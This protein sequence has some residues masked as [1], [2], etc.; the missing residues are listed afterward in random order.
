MHLGIGDPLRMAVVS[1][2]APT[3]QSAVVGASV[4]SR[5][6]PTLRAD[7]AAPIT[8]TVKALNAF[9]PRLLVG[10]ASAL[11]ELAAEQAAGRLRIQ[12][13]AVI[14]ASEVLTATTA[15]DL[16]AAWGHEPF[17]V[18]AATETAGIASP[19]Q[20]HRRHLYEDLVICEVV[21]DTGA[22]VPAG[23]TGSRLL[24]TVLFSRTLPLIR[25]ELSD[26]VAL[27]PSSCPCARP[28]RTLAGVEGR[29]EDIL[30]LPG[31]RGAV[32]GPPQR[33]ARSPSTPCRSPAGRSSRNR[34]AYYAC[35]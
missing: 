35:W 22:P 11:R 6:V 2:L 18:Y 23:T 1:S 25:Y 27:D 17:D 31:A 16:A 30:M 9:A 28:F 21:D 32:R 33:P 20:F 26:R 29:Q 5:L 4:H 12:P 3:H 15:R 7:A 13:Q 10:Y 24:V 14:S 34:R 8:D 19:C